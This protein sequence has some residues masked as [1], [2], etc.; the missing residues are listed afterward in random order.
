MW[1]IV[2]NTGK[3]LHTD[4][5]DIWDWPNTITY[6]VALRTKYDSFLELSEIP[7][8]EYWDYPHKIRDWIERLYP[9]MKK[10][11]AEFSTDDVEY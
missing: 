6:L 1:G 10:S 11:S 2:K 5:I 9:G 7:P 3:P 4:L 8:E